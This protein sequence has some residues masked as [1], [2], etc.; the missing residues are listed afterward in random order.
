MQ[1]AILSAKF[2]FLDAWNQKRV[3]HAQRYMELLKHCDKIQLPQLNQVSSHVYNQF[4]IQSNLRDDL[5]ES[6]YSQGIQ[7][8]IQFPLAMHQQ[9][10]YRNMPKVSLPNSEQLSAK[11]ISLPVHAQ[12]DPGDVD[13]VAQ[14]VLDFFN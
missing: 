8:G 14:A 5:Y 13:T 12:L 2:D 7:A 4:V 1:A 10:V 9:P 6:L 11:C 3:K